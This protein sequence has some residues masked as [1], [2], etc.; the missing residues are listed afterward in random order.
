MLDRNSDNE[1]HVQKTEQPPS[2]PSIA[3]GLERIGLVGM[4]APILSCII[5]LAL[6]V[7]AIFGIQQSKIDEALSQLFRS[8]CKY[9]QQYEAEVK[10]FPATECDF[11]VVV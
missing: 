8:N 9:Y 4:R 3:F 7:A 10:L 5:L 1:V 11:L 2:G 6:I